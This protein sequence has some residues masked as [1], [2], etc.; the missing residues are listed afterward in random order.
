[1]NELPT[2]C[3]N[4]KAFRT[5]LNMYQKDMAAKLGVSKDLYCKVETGKINPTYNFLERLV[6]AFPDISINKILFDKNIF[7]LYM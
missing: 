1:M 4:L 7:K 6:K 2:H 5:S 3:V